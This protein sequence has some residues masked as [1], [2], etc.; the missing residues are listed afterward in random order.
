M[1]ECLKKKQAYSDQKVASEEPF[2]NIVTVYTHQK[3]TTAGPQDETRMRP[4]SSLAIMLII[5]IINYVLN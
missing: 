1:L 2:I 4:D 3:G 5:I